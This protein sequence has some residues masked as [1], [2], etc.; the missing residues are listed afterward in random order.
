MPKCHVLLKLQQA[1]LVIEAHVVGGTGLPCQ[2]QVQRAADLL[3]TSVEMSD[4]VMEE[5]CVLVQLC[6]PCLLQ[7]AKIT[8]GNSTN[9]QQNEADTGAEMIS[10]KYLEDRVRSFCPE[11]T[12]QESLRRKAELMTHAA[13]IV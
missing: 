8:M 6:K 9:N 7:M 12:S 13:M 11:A 1:L 3:Y 4:C 5:T 10:Q 2:V